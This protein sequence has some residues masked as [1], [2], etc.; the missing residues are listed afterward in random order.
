MALS[1]KER[2][3]KKREQEKERRKRISEDP[4][5]VAL[6]NEKRRNRYHKKRK[7]TETQQ[8]KKARQK[9]WR[10]NKR[11]YSRKINKECD[12]LSVS[13]RAAS[14]R[15][16]VKLRAELKRVKNCLRVKA[17]EDKNKNLN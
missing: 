1:R 12:E 14:I 16:K 11:K 9:K 5:L 2:L 3:E 15:R 8:Q 10:E 7:Q 17:L 4:E 13:T 6:E